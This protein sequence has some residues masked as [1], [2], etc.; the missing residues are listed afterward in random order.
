MGDPNPTVSRKTEIHHRSTDAIQRAQDVE[1][2]N[3]RKI[4]FTAW[5]FA[6]LIPIAIGVILAAIFHPSWLHLK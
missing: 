1:Q 4:R 6:L 5:L 2:A 3:A